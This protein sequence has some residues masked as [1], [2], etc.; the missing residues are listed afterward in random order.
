MAGAGEGLV[1]VELCV[2]KA[3]ITSDLPRAER[4]D[5]NAD[6]APITQYIDIYWRS[7]PCMCEVSKELDF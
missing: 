3:V 1:D 7:I 6:A 4:C 2:Y 5:A